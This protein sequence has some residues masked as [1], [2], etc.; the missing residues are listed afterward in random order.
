M[1]WPK[2]AQDRPQEMT[3]DGQMDPHREASQSPET[4]LGKAPTCQGP[5]FSLIRFHRAAEARAS[6]GAARDAAFHDRSRIL[7]LG[8]G[9]IL[10]TA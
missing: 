7:V 6:E 3:E 8:I 9:Y 4:L 5:H 1:N 10:S 2:Q